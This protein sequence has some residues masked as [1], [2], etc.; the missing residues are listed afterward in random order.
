MASKLLQRGDVQA[1]DA[2]VRGLLRGV[3]ACASNFS[4]QYHL[5]TTE[6]FEQCRRYSHLEQK[7]TL[8]YTQAQ[9]QELIEEMV[10]IFRSNPGHA[11]VAIVTKPPETVLLFVDRH[12]A[13]HLFDSHRRPDHEGAALLYFEDDRQLLQYLQELFPPAES[14]GDPEMDMQMLMYEMVD[15]LSLIHI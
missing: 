13:L 14:T 3:L 11:V 9:F 6:V 15:A 10:R 1:D 2:E 5:D 7:R 8:Q 12:G 4:S